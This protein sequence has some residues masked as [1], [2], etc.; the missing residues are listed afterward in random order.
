MGKKFELRAKVKDTV[1][2]AIGTIT[3]IHQR[4]GADDN[5]EL[6]YMADST[7]KELWVPVGRLE[8]VED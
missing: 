5:C 2:G 8:P 3:A 4:V 7:V 1:T 6:T